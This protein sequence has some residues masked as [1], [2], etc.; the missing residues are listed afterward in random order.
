MSFFLKWLSFLQTR[1]SVFFSKINIA[2]LK[3]SWEITRRRN[4]RRFH[5]EF[6]KHPVSL[7]TWPI[8]GL[9]LVL[10]VVIFPCV[11][12]SELS[13]PSPNLQRHAPLKHFNLDYM[14]KNRI[15]EKIFVENQGHI[16]KPYSVIFSVFWLLHVSKDASYNEIHVLFLSLLI[17]FTF[18]LIWLKDIHWNLD[19]TTMNTGVFLQNLE[20]AEILITKTRPKYN[21]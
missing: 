4:G 10:L 14:E 8:I 12:F 18:R 5:S 11:N 20:L 16:R 1:T 6:K 21:K 9:F 13:K 15:T 17:S 3:K 7:Q 2:P 19:F